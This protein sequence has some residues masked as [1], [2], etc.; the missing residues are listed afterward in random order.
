MVNYVNSGKVNVN[1]EFQIILKPYISLSIPYYW[2]ITGF[3]TRLRRRMP[4]AEQEL[5]TLPEFLGSLPVL[6]GFLLLDL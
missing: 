6:V 2:L 5:L 1:L 3:V 4:L